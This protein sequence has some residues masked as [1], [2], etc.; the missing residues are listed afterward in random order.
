MGSITL[1]TSISCRC[2]K[3]ITSS[4]HTRV[5]FWPTWRLGIISDS[6]FN[7]RPPFRRSQTPLRSPGLGPAGGTRRQAALTPLLWPPRGHGGGR[8]R[9]IRH[10]MAFSARNFLGNQAFGSFL[11]TCRDFAFWTKGEVRLKE[12]A[13][14]KSRFAVRALHGLDKLS[15]LRG[16]EPDFRVGRQQPAVGVEQTV[17]SLRPAR[18][19]VEAPLE[20][21]R[22][23]VEPAPGRLAFPE[24]RVTRIT[25]FVQNV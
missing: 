19:P 6:S 12:T 22:D 5:S 10:T 14:R 24:F 13:N 18:Q 4:I 2:V 21:F 20:Y 9:G 3:A 15:I 8:K 1:R 17:Q 16:G 7:K 11:T 23:R 25:P